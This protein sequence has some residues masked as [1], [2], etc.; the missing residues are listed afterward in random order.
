MLKPISKAVNNVASMKFS[1]A[2]G[3]KIVNHMTNGR[4]LFSFILMDGVINPLL[5][6]PHGVNATE[7]QN[8]AA[9]RGPTFVEDLLVFY[10]MLIDLL[11]RHKRCF[12]IMVDISVI[13]AQN[14]KSLLLGA[15]AEVVFLSIPE[16]EYR[17]K[18]SDLVEDSTGNQHAKPNSGGDFGIHSARTVGHEPRKAVRSH[19]FRK[20]VR[21]VHDRHR[22]NRGV[23]RKGTYNAGE[24][25]A[26]EAAVHAVEPLG[27]HFGVRVQDY[28]GVP[29]Q[30]EP[31]VHIFDKTAVPLRGQHVDAAVTLGI[32]L[33]ERQDA[34]VRTRIVEKID[35]VDRVGMCE[36]AFNA[37]LHVVVSII[38]GDQDVIRVVT[39]GQRTG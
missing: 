21:R 26:A 23:V 12:S 20:M 10:T 16:S 38:N 29:R 3:I 17:I 7:G 28:H 35:G 9:V 25:S 2:E 8:I 32:R 13:A 37:H 36:D 19:L 5:N 4:K 30:R 18:A 22:E 27:G 15:F 1:A 34:K 6:F 11:D 14:F 33:K 24:R 31:P 39:A